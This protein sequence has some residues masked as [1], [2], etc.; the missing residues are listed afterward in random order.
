MGDRKKV[1]FLLVVF[2][3]VLS[4]LFAFILGMRY[5]S[6][7][8]RRKYTKKYILTHRKILVAKEDIGDSEIIK[9]NM[10]DLVPVYKVYNNANIGEKYK[11]II[12]GRKAIYPIRKGEAISLLMIKPTKL[13][14]SN[15]LKEK[16]LDGQRK[17]NS[18]GL[19]NLRAL[20]I[21]D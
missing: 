5:S 7:Y 16:F 2:F 13:I 4:I 3:Y 9:E 18:S 1:Y 14:N 15:E 11:N 19:A 6:F 21:E 20:T 17:K 10:L 8:E 12:I